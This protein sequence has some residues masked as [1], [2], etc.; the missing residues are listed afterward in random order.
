[1]ITREQLIEVGRFVKPHGIAGEL[2]AAFDIDNDIAATLPCLVAD[3]DGIFVPFFVDNCRAKGNNLLLTIDGIQSDTDAATLADKAIYAT[4]TDYDA[5]MRQYA[6]DHGD[7]WP[8]DFFI[9]FSLLAEPDSHRVGTIADIDDATTNVLFLVD[10][11]G[12]LRVPVPAAEPLITD[13]DTR[14]RTITM[15]IPDGLL[16]INSKE[17]LQ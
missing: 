14:L 5:R 12:G 17:P 2:Q 3:I 10:T 15:Q 13:I 8:V 6:D 9:G 16:E 7:E 4:K 1:M 11:D